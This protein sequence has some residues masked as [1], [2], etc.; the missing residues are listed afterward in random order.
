[1]GGE[2]GELDGGGGKGGISN[3]ILYIILYSIYI[4]TYIYG[5]YMNNKSPEVF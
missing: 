5:K 3:V 1:M 2:W 4:I